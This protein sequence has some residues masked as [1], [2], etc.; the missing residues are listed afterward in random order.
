M[1][2]PHGR[3]AYQNSLSPANAPYFGVASGIFTNYSWTSPKIGLA[4]Q[5][6]LLELS[7]T[8]SAALFRSLSDVYMGIDVFARGSVGGLDTPKALEL[9]APASQSSGL[10]TALFAPGW[11]WEHEDRRWPDWWDCLLYTSDAADE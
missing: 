8:T 3:I 6:A 1:I 9:I 7:R 5:R 10:S 4:R 11:T 2:Y